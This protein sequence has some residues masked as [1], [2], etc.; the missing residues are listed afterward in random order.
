MNNTDDQIVSNKRFSFNPFS[1]QLQ[2]FESELI[3]NNIHF[4]KNENSIRR[5][6]IVFSFFEKDIERVNEIYLDIEK[7]LIKQEEV[8]RKIKKKKKDAPEVKQRKIAIY[9]LA[10]ILIIILFSIML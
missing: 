10:V 9:I 7:T 3:E 1:V 8:Y 2:I 5:Q 6:E 4:V